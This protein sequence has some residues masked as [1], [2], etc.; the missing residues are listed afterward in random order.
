MRLTYPD[1][2]PGP[3]SCGEIFAIVL[4]LTV[5]IAFAVALFN[6]QKAL[7]KQRPEKPTINQTAPRQRGASFFIAT[8]L[9][10]RLR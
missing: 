4:L 6:C 10:F 3:L 5:L 2:D 8:A 7:V 9:A 1:Q